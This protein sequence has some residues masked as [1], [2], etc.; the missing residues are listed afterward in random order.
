M[1]MLSHILGVGLDKVSFLRF[2]ILPYSVLRSIYLRCGVPFRA[3]V[4]NLPSPALPC[5]IITHV[6]YYIHDTSGATLQSPADLLPGTCREVSWSEYMHQVRA[7][8][9]VRDSIMYVIV[10]LR[11]YVQEM[12]AQE[13]GKFIHRKYLP[14]YP[15]NILDVEE[16]VHD[17]RTCAT[18]GEEIRGAKNKRFCGYMCRYQQDRARQAGR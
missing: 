4:D 13:N 11:H 17:K 3:P 14:P 12:E 5:G 2:S 15:S 6:N 1:A 7:N 18:C 16:I 8:Q 10:N 9:E